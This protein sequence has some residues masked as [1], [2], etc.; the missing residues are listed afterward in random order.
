[1]I[2]L[3]A[4]YAL[5]A[6]VHLAAS[7]DWP[8]QTVGQIAAGTQ[9]PVGYLA[10]VLQSLARARIIVSQ[11]GLGGGF[12]IA[13]SPASISI[14]EVVQAVD[15]L[16]RI[17]T[18]PLNLEAHSTR[19]CPLHKRL[20]SSMELIEQQFRATMISEL[21]DEVAAPKRDSA[22]NLCVFPLTQPVK[23]TPDA[24]L[25]TAPKSA[26]KGTRKT[27]PEAAPKPTKKA[28]TMGRK[29]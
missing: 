25:K 1:M 21:I 26:R 5:R 12:R 20:D 8:S 10:K 28:R 4:E 3:T 27:T 14:Y 2:S 16:Q 7:T 19:L 24:T 6:M 15:P 29:S 17:R 18:C 11:R 22:R 13:R 23:S 9:V